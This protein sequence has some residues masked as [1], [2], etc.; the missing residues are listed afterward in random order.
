MP[1]E[2]IRVVDWTIFQQG[3]VV[4][5]MLG[6]LGAEVIKIEERGR[7][8]PGRGIAGVMGLSPKLPGGRNYYFEANNRNKKS[9][10]LDLKKPQAREI[11]YRLVEK[12]DVFVQNFRKGVAERLGLDYETL[13]RYNPRLIYA[14]ATGYG[15]EGPESHRPSLDPVGL[16]R[17]GFMDAA[18]PA[19]Q[20]PIYMQGGIADQMGAIMLAYGILAALVARERLGIG[21]KVDAS[22]LGSM[23]WLQSLSIHAFLLM[24][25]ELPKWRRDRA[26]NPMFNYYRCAD[27]KWLFLSLMQPDRHWSNFCQA[28][29]RP[30]LEHDPRFDTADKRRE[31]RSELIR[32]LDGIFATK[33]CREWIEI[34]SRYPDFIFEPVN[35]YADLPDDPQ[36]R[37]NDYIVD[38]DHPVLGKVKM[39]GVPVKLSKTPGGIRLPAPEYGQHT[40]EVLLDICGYSWEDIERFRE[41]E[42]I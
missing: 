9:I 23:M 40:E 15:P 20:P 26:A 36:V 8:D 24:G 35:S 18:A 2:G 33:T 25:K 30:D 41:E 19:E 29:G 4:T 3:P 28:I 39:V 16:A 38:F 5:A 10:A 12:S 27:G 32:I 22:H 1:L 17:A 14:S 37:A 42:I 13:S 21:Q 34:L 31:N 7:G 6:D 11:V